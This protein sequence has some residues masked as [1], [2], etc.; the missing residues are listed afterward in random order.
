VIDVDGLVEDRP[1]ALA[2]VAG[3]LIAPCEEWGVFQIVGHGI[4]RD[5]L[6]R[7]ERA[8]VAFFE[9]PAAVRDAVRRT[10]D[11]A[12]GYYDAEL[13]KNRPD[14]KEV[15]DYGAERD[16]AAAEAA[17][18][19]GVN[20]W[21]AGQPEL[22]DALLAHHRA[23]ERVGMAL[24]RALCLSLGVPADTLAPF[25]ANHSSFVR[26][27]RYT[28]NPDAA[29]PDAPLFPEH[30]RLG[31]HHHTD[32]GALTLLVQDDV[33]GLQAWRGDAFVVVDPVPGALLVNLADMLQ[34]WSNDRYRS[35][36]HRVLVNPTRT[37]HSAPFFLNPDYE[38]VCEP[39]PQLLRADAPARFRP[40]SWAHFRDQRSAGDY[41]DY[42]AE[43]QIEDF[44]TSGTAGPARGRPAV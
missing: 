44:R 6:A 20:Q 4:D 26:L 38:T 10:R 37:R 21:P 9:L 3:E 35:P 41:A 18:S 29:P 30:G 36:L 1:G 8:M 32:A 5:A 19:D 11:N 17:H 22:R 27:N 14:W 12:R 23:C 24:L 39:L 34:I 15:F 31:V 28:A 13:T 42:G 2:R 7:F 25:F 16:P 40:V 43:I 33:A